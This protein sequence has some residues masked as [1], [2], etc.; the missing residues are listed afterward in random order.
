MSFLTQDAALL[1][2]PSGGMVA[3]GVAAF[4]Y[5]RKAVRAERRAGGLEIR[6]R[7]AEQQVAARDA[8][9]GHL[10]GIRLPALVDAL[11]R[12]GG[13]THRDGGLLHAHLAGTPVGKAYAGVLEQV[14]ALATGASE[15][16][17]G[18]SRAAVQA[19][20]RSFQALVYEQQTAITALLESQH[21][22][23]VLEFAIPIDHAGS[24]LAR[25]AQIVGV[26]TGMW[27]GRQRDDALLLEAVRGGISR[28][29]DYRRV[30]ITGERGEYVAGRF[31]EPVVLAVA[32]LL[33]NA[34]RHSEPGTLVE[35]WFVEAHNG[36]SIVIDDAGIGLSPEERERA[37]HLLSGAGP[38]RLTELRTPPRF[39]FLATGV[40]AAQYGFKV[41]VEQ[42]SVHGGVRAVLHLPRALLARPP[43]QQ[44]PQQPA[45]A[46]APRADE[47][48]VVPPVP[49]EHPYPVAGD[50]LPVR[51]R[52]R[53]PK[54]DLSAPP[55]AVPPAAG[56]GS[57]LAAFLR[58][59]HS[60]RHLSADQEPSS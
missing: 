37:A 12:G 45:A 48:A 30:R 35:V 57:D 27:P 26:L 54:P 4:H 17:E 34:A 36:I 29:R 22:E 10:A 43:A 59:T 16:A 60:A 53:G 44:Q 41:S 24:Q 49:A 7:A 15:R 11:N 31:V 13:G 6:A 1:L 38:V 47:P 28:I 51:R 58:G 20:V 2:A 33:D 32:E 55:P 18:A 23:R 56:A 14:S 40:L 46:P 19:V 39:G 5:R 3:A 21:D 50:G 9:A 42:Q 52:R 25:R 8:E